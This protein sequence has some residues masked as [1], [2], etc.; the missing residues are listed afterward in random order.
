MAPSAHPRK[1]G[2]DGKGRVRRA[3]LRLRVHLDAIT[4]QPRLYFQGVGW[5]IRGLRLRS[6][7][8]FSALMG[9]SPRAYALWM[10]SR[11]P[12]LLA[13]VPMA[14]GAPAISIIVD[15]R[16]GRDGLTDTMAS[17][18][19]LQG[20]R[21]PVA[22]LGCAESIDGE[23][24]ALRDVSALKAWIAEA[25]GKPWIVVV[26]CGDRL[27]PAALEAYREQIVRRPDVTLV[28]ADDDLI[29]G[30]GV[31][32]RPHFKPDWNAELFQHHDYLT[33]SCA[34]ACDPAK[35]SDTWPEDTYDL[36]VAP[37]HV[38]LVLH[39]RRDRPAPVIPAVPARLN[40]DELPHVSIIVPTRNHAALL[41]TCMAGLS[42]TRYPSFDVTVV[43]NDS[44][45][46]ATI[47]Y[48]A[49]LRG[50]GVRVEAFPGPFDYAALHNAVVPSLAG[51]LI[52]LLNNDIEVIDPDWLRIMAQAATR[53]DVG[54]VGA[55]LLYPDRTIQHAG[56]VIGVGGGAGHAH[57]LQSDQEAGYFG[58]AH[59]PQTIS[60]VTAACLV[61]RRDRFEAVGGFDCEN[62]T[63]AFN[64][65]DLCLKL[66]ARGWQSFYE[67]RACLIHHESKS[68][69]LDDSPIKKARFAGELAA[70]KRKW[71]TDRIHDPFHHPELSQFGEQFVVRL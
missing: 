65:V 49:E 56:I 66:N 31:R 39:H 70:L 60:A 36:T 5:R 9:H 68:R 50:K 10:A 32:E 12:A 34:F 17:I 8:R 38:P 71:A 2:G 67:A 42:E 53:E 28:Y 22:L 64:D 24:I 52:C 21:P 16:A 7:H 4:A 58:R 11:E 48:L 29:D 14:M 20:E 30:R 51:P 33:G 41:R 69:G 15:C 26:G 13:Q 46:P 45:D 27:A 37:V 23:A 47:A 43:D 62:F 63:V 44:D 1:V 40:D 59:L 57:R 61:V 6:R 35:S 25:G 54:A 55:R 19:G 3:L 18:R